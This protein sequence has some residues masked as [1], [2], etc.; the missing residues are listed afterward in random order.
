MPHL[1]LEW[2]GGN[3][4]RNRMDARRWRKNAKSKNPQ[5]S[6]ITMSLHTCC[7]E[8]KPNPATNPQSCILSI[9]WKIRHPLLSEAVLL[10][11]ASA[12]C[13]AWNSESRAA[14]L[15]VIVKRTV[16]H[17]NEKCPEQSKS[18]WLFGWLIDRF[19]DCVQGWWTSSLSCSL[20]ETIQKWFMMS[21]VFI[22][23]ELWQEE[24]EERRETGRQ[25]GRQRSS[26]ILCQLF[27]CNLCYGGDWV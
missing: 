20:G 25:T 12:G 27:L 5:T 19:I 10:S 4:R 24:G 26:V 11:Q 15:S 1:L 23:S 7:N 21:V 18:D 16:C 2:N 14:C 3:E 6:H 13:S 8:P 9:L 22:Q 17:L